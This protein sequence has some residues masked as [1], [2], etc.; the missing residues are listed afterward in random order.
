MSRLAIIPICLVQIAGLVLAV[1]GCAAQEMRGGPPERPPP[2]RNLPQNLPPSIPTGS[3]AIAPRTAG[4][5]AFTVDDAKAYVATHH[6]PMGIGREGKPE[7]IRAEFL[8]SREVSNRLNGATT[9]FPDNYPLCYVE[10]QGPFTFSGPQGAKV[11]YNRGVLIFD[12]HTGNLV[13]GGG[14]P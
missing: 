5:P 2:I 14:M 6:I 1:S 7:I 4:T 10:L 12:A 8:S 13:I 3:P 9:G 11:T